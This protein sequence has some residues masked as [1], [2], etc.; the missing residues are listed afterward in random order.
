M[1]IAI[2]DFIHHYLINPLFDF[3][4]KIITYSGNDG[5]IFIIFTLFFLFNKKTRK[6]GF[7]AGVSLIIGALITN[8]FLKDYVARIRP[9]DVQNI[10]ILIKEPTD[11]SFPS[12][13]TTAAFAFAFVLLKEKFKIGN[14]GVYKYAIIFAIL[15]AFSRMYFYVHYPSDVLAGIII[16]YIA[17]VLSIKI[18][19]K[20]RKKA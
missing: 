6:L 20:I 18:V 11:F 8:V 15:M 3:I 9:Y 12:G 1:E 4:F 17:S 14:Y 13:H 7:Y 19:S 5:V 2:L 10:A 16:G